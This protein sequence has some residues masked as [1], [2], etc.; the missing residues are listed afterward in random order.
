[1]DSFAVADITKSHTLGGLGN[2]N[3]R[4]PV[5]KARCSEGDQGVA[6]LVPSE[7]C[8]RDSVPGLSL[9]PGTLLVISGGL[10]LADASP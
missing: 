3:L 7:G 10:A 1:M 4:V 2:R 6:G 9:A 8:G 5:L